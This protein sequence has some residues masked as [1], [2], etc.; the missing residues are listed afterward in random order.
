MIHQYLVPG[1]SVGVRVTAAVQRK[2]AS[3]V[4]W[5]RYSPRALKSFFRGFES[6][7][8]HTRK[9]FFSIK[10]DQR[11]ARERELLI[12]TFD[13]SRR[14]VGT[15][16]STRGKHEGTYR[17]G[18]RDDTCD[19]GFS[20]R[21]PRVKRKSLR[22]VDL[23]STSPRFTCHVEA[24]IEATSRFLMRKSFAVHTNIELLIPCI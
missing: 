19:H 3:P 13:E 15:L 10:I 11:K 20:R 2:P 16:N 23:E 6:H 24:S 1:I 8:V 9:D 22:R 14:A 17:G 4:G 7:R 18:R 12:A 21:S 5:H